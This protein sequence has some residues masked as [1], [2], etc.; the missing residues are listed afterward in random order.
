MRERLILIVVCVIVIALVYAGLTQ[1]YFAPAQTMS[2]QTQALAAQLEDVTARVGRARRE[3]ATTATTESIA[4]M[5]TTGE[6]GADTAAHF[7]ET[8]RAQVAQSGGAAVSSQSVTSDLGG[9]FAKV[10]VLLRARFRE[11]ALLTFLRAVELQQPIML[12]ENLA[13]RPLPVAG[14]DRPLDV[15]AT[16]TE[17]H[18]DAP[19]S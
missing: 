17:F 7:Q 5:V 8:A 19:S 15:T 11:A 1:L 6:P 16:L 9:G 2:Q 13:V 10:S 18:A 3:L 4:L 12:V 14:D